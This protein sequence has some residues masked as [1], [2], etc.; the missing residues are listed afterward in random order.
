MPWTKDLAGYYPLGLTVGHDWVKKRNNQW[1][2]L[3][4][5]GQCSESFP[6]LTPMISLGGLTQV[7][8]IQ[9][10]L[11]CR[12]HLRCRFQAK[13][14]LFN[15]H[16]CSP[17]RH[18]WQKEDHT[19]NPSSMQLMTSWLFLLTLPSPIPSLFLILFLAPLFYFSSHCQELKHDLQLL[20]LLCILLSLC[21]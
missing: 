19:C 14:Q 10:W 7:P 12:W 6:F 9:H 13:A 16:F 20:P 3:S 18:G 11:L 21:H 4:L 8:W 2:K 5:A 15:L 17:T 1:E